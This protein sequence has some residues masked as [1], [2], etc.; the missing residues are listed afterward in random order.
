MAA[1]AGD[2]LLRAVHDHN[3]WWTEGVDA[4]DLPVRRK[5]DYY[6]LARP[7]EPGSQFED[8][9][10]LGLVGRRGVGKTTLLHQFVHDS[11]AEDGLA[12]ERFCYL[13][14]DA[15]PLY[16]L[17]SDDQLRRTVRYYESRI[18]GRL[19]E[20]APQFLL[21]DDVHRIE[22]PDKSRIDGW[23]TPV[24][25]LLDPGARY[26]A[27]TASAAVQARRELE[28]AGVDEDRYD[29]QP[30]L[31]EKF[32]DHLFSRF[33]DLEADDDRRV[34]PS[35]FR[36]GEGSLP[37]AVTSGDLEPLVET[38]R[39]AHRKVAGYE[40]RIQSQ[41]VEFLAMGGT[42]SYAHSG[43]DV[44]SAGD[45]PAGAY[46][47][48]R[49]DVRDALYQDVPGFES[50]KT[51]ADLERLCALAARSRARTPVPFRE[52]ADLFDVDRR[53][54]AD[55]Y[56]SAL[57][58]MYVLDGV[59]EYDNRRPRAVRLYLR[60]TGLATALAWGSAAAVRN[61]FDHEAELA[62]VSGFDHTMRLEYGVRSAHSGADAPPDVRYWRGDDGEVDY[63]FD[64]A[65][66]PVPVGLAYRPGD[67]ADS[68]AA[69]REFQ[70]TY[71]A[72]LGLLLTGDTVPDEDPVTLAE[73]VVEV[74]FWLYL[75]I[76]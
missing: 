76:C 20:E 9:P 2:A 12:P 25:D 58:R 72:P 24:A 68:L 70:A 7:D 52:L 36:T 15:D 3:P 11:I 23:G 64:V 49:E 32:R 14:F 45:L 16:Q 65:E 50:I 47:S 71:D 73:G 59:T 30:I 26:V 37:H 66:T 40:R 54:I 17:R 42:I 46:D 29:V 61:D 69:V 34:S 18:V 57:S 39:T 19:D 55:S 35:P 74:P 75:L 27:V 48:L 4:F 31:P 22:H 8:Q 44:R 13:P 60:D 63:V 41:V 62:R 1:D 38:F 67:R 33:D 56:L 51:I 43:D 10:L 6:H 53:T 5:S 28:R 21:L